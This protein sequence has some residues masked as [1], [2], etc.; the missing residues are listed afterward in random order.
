MNR[1]WKRLRNGGSRGY[2]VYGGTGAAM[3]ITRKF[4][5]AGINVCPRPSVG[6]SAPSRRACRWGWMM[7][8]PSSKFLGIDYVN[9]VILRRDCF[10]FHDS[11]ANC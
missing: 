3:A 11:P 8:V 6:A 1:A 4:L 2:P 7:C 10:T 5:W 9:G